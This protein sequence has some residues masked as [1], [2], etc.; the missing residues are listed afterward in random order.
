MKKGIFICV[1]IFRTTRC[2]SVSNGPIYTKIGLFSW[3]A[4]ESYKRGF[5]IEPFLSW[6][7][8]FCFSSSVSKH[9]VVSNFS[10]VSLMRTSSAFSM[11]LAVFLSIFFVSVMAN[12]SAALLWIIF[13]SSSLSD[14]FSFAIFSIFLGQ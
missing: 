6:S 14:R 7:S 3:C 11:A 12:C 9:K 2:V 1:S 4:K 10:S 5:L 8:R 13:R